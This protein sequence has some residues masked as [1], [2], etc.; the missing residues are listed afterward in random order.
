MLDLSIQPGFDYGVLQEKE[1]EWFGLW[2][3]LLDCF[4]LVHRDFELLRRIHLLAMSKILTV[5]VNLNPEL[6]KQNLID[7][8]C[9]SLWT[10]P[11]PEEINF[12]MIFKEKSYVK[13]I[14]SIIPKIVNNPEEVNIF[15]SWLIFLMKWVKYIDS[16]SRPDREFMEYV[17]GYPAADNIKQKIYQALVIE[18]DI[19]TAENLIHELIRNNQ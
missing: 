15:Q 9:A 5:I 7:N 12:T 6:G 19:M 4:L 16:I 2:C 14:E 8:S 10:V 1:L 17:M 13:S 18:N 11:N 3:P